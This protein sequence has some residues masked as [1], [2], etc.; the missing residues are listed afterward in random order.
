ME[1]GDEQ[2]PESRLIPL[3]PHLREN[4]YYD[5]ELS[6][7]LEQNESYALEFWDLLKE[8]WEESN[9][10]LTPKD[11]G[12][13]FDEFKEEIC[14]RYGVFDP[15]EAEKLTN[16]EWYEELVKFDEGQ[17]SRYVKFRPEAYQRFSLF[18]AWAQGTYDDME[19]IAAVSG[20]RPSELST[21]YVASLSQRDQLT[22]LIEEAMLLPHQKNLI[23]PEF[24]AYLKKKRV[25]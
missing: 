21:D 15:E 14:P 2:P 25:L 24:F 3:P 10:S 20:V 13:I 17:P 5:P 11:V 1:Q 18:D 23:P 19:H 22:A 12:K 16:E 4:V 7:K 9:Y 8:K 6:P